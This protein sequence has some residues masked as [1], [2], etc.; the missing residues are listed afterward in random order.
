MIN[1][2]DLHPVRVRYF[3]GGYQRYSQAIKISL[4]TIT[5]HAINIVIEVKL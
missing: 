3:S 4:T 1:S 2:S 5:G